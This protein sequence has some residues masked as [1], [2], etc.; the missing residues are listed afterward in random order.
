MKAVIIAAATLLIIS[1]SVLRAEPVNFTISSTAVYSPDEKVQIS[2]YSY[3][4]SEESMKKRSLSVEF[5]L[6]KIEDAERFYSNQRS[7]YMNDLLAHDSSS[8]L[9]SLRKV[10]SFRKTFRA[11]NEYGYSSINDQF[12][13]NGH[14]K[15]AYL[16]KGVSGNSIAYCGFIITELGL[17]SKAGLNTMGGFAADRKSGASALNSSMVFYAG[18]QKVGEAIAADGSAFVT[19]DSDLIKV[20]EEQMRPL[21]IVRKGDDMAVSDPYFFFGYRDNRYE[22]YMFTEQPVYR[23]GSVVNFKGT[24]RKRSVSGYENVPQKRI[25]VAVHDYKSTE[26]YKEETSTNDIGSFACS[27]KLDDEAVTGDY[28]ISV[29]LEGGAQEVISFTVE[30][31]KKPEYKVTVTADKN[32]YYGDELLTAEIDARYFFGSPVTQASVEYEIHRV[33]FYRPWWMFSEYADWYREYYEGQ[34]ESTYGAELINRGS[35][36]VD[37]EGRLKIEYQ[38]NEEFREINEFDWYRPYRGSSDYKYMIVARVTDNARHSISGNSSVFVTRAAY[39]LSANAGSYLYKPGETVTI[40]VNAADFTEKPVNA[41]F[42]ANIYRYENTR[43]SN[44]ERRLVTVLEGSTRSDGKGSVTYDLP[45]IA[46]EGAYYVDVTSTDE[47]SKVVTATAYFYVSSGDFS[48]FSTYGSDMQI[49]TDKESYVEGDVCKAVIVSPE[50][51]IDILV[52][53]ETENINFHTVKKLTGTTINVEIPVTDKYLSGFSVS[54]NYIKNGANYSASKRV[55]V[56]PKKK[57]LTVIVEP[58]QNIYKPKEQGAL[59]I[60]VVDDNGAP[61]GNAEVSIGIVDES[62]YSI[63]PDK[64]KS[65]DRFFYGKISGE[66]STGFN[67]ART[68]SGNSRLMTI[69]EKFGYGDKSRLGTIHGIVR[70]ENGEPVAGAVIIVDDDYYAVVTGEDGNYSFR[71]PEGR[72]EVGV[73][74]YKGVTVG[75]IARAEAG[76]GTRCDMRVRA[77][78]IIRDI[79]DLGGEFQNEVRSGDRMVTLEM[80]VQAPEMDRKSKDE[81]ST[82]ES[83]VE[84][85]KADV[86][87]DFRDAILW[88]PMVRTDSQGY[89]D[90]TVSYPDNLTSWKITSRVMTEDT[91]VGQAVSTVVTR[92]D[93][94]VRL[95]APRFMRENDI[96]TVSAIVHNY[97]DSEKKTKISFRSEN[98]GLITGSRSQEIVIEADSE[99]RV[100][101]QVTPE[102]VSG[103]AVLYAEA[104]TNEESDAMELKVPV[105]PAGLKLQ[106]SITADFSDEL[107]T[108]TKIIEV[109]Q[110]VNTGSAGLTINVDPSL[111]S[112]ILSSLD[113]L[114]GYPYGCVEQTMSRFLPT[115]IVATAFGK[116]NAPISEKTKSVIPKMVSKGLTRL[117]SLQHGDGGWGWWENDKS[118]PFMTAYVVYGFSIAGEAGYEVNSLSYKRGKVSIKQQLAEPLTDATTKAYMLYALSISGDDEL[119]FV[120]EELGKLNTDDLNNYGKS[121][122]ALAWKRIGEDKKAK[123]VVNDLKSRAV[124]LPGEGAAYWEGK[125]FHYNWQDDKIQTTAMALKALVNIDEG[126]DLK[127]LVIRWLILQRQGT[128]WRSTQETAMIVYSMTDYLMTSKELDPDYNVNVFLNGRNVFRK[129]MTRADVFE[130]SSTVRLEGSALNPGINELRIE[131]S[132]KGKVYFAS[133]LSY[134]K[135][136]DQVKAEEDGFRVEKEVYKLTEYHEYGGD[137]IIYRTVPFSGEVR[138]GDVLLF[139]VRVHSSDEENNYFM[140]EDPFPSGFEYVKDDWAYKVEGERD[141]SGYER[142]YW[143]W[144]YADKDVRDDR[145]V[146]FATY[147]GKGIH[148]F[149]YLM[150]AEI[151]GEY[152]VNPSKGMLMY[153]PEVYGNSEGMRIKVN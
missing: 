112:T 80:N 111:A 58:S 46:A 153:Y 78:E 36:V 44:E 141:F 25:S 42:K 47:R 116:L 49:V 1:A 107:K 71:I 27:F 2:F 79:P 146:F 64:T 73:L 5:T 100:D 109:P 81:M 122:V 38:I 99:K 54:A 60:K 19:F 125:K 138:S 41:D 106:K 35:G 115:V 34:E 120:K 145:I 57:L 84:Y 108:E 48:W 137:R 33:P 113:D 31:F 22:T 17:I 130:K 66:V 45:S 90:V 82:T 87:S 3:S 76:A 15:G 6:Y 92:K 53:A 43:Y 97:L 149:T 93:L 104:L 32:R 144:W 95:E 23:A 127:D 101:F 124:R 126:S 94:L 51:G 39:Y 85:V 140:L 114:V 56:V 70:D 150:R 4:Y 20:N 9:S 72:Y 7:A 96:V 132:G 68:S 26:V 59:R 91:K 8:L 74:G 121:L 88:S 18:S 119:E 37:S 61:V 75:K 50:S 52:T 16:L 69:F 128:S 63:R 14:G 151:P 123:Q 65:I 98:A 13:L 129:Q 28:N 143:R 21:V 103:D 139:K 89:A 136:M 40:N 11:K 12:S 131:K 152:T 133:A 135:P 147:F 148:E 86:R 83:G 77:D 118:N 110:G 117:Y 10:N 102:I 29:T 55:I 134:Y 24:V 67:T 142:Y 62:I 105:H 30:Q